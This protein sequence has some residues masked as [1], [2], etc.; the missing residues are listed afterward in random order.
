MAP[1]RWVH[2]RRRSRGCGS[3][4]R[5]RRW[6]LR[7]E[8]GQVSAIA[9]ILALLL[10]VTFIANYLTT[11]LPNQMAINDLQRDL[12][13][14]NQVGRL[15]TLLQ[16]VTSPPSIGVQVS[17]P[18]TLGSSG[19]PPFAG[20]D[21]GSL[22]ALANGSAATVAY[23]LVG[24]TDLVTPSVTA[25]GSS[26]PAGTCTITTTAVTCASGGGR[27]WGNFTA[28]N[29][30]FTATLTAGETFA[31]L[32]YSTSGSTIT[33]SA[34]STAATHVEV[35]GSSDTISVSN[36]GATV[37]NVTV[38]GS[39]DT[40][41]LANSGGGGKERALIVGSND[42][43]SATTGGSSLFAISFFGSS[44]TF[45]PP[46]ATSSGANVYAVYFN[47][48]STSSPSL[49]CPQGNVPTNDQV[50]INPS[51]WGN[52]NT[53]KIFFNDTSGTPG[54]TT[55][56]T[57]WTNTTQNP[58]AFAC[59]FVAQ[60]SIPV[61]SVVSPG[62]GFDVHLANTYAPI[63]DVALDEGA[64]VFSQAG[65]S[66]VMEDGPQISLTES[67]T[68][69]TSLAI[70]FPV[71]SGVGAFPSQSGYGT[72]DVVAR[73]LAVT[74]ISLSSGGAFSLSPTSNVVLTV[75]TAFATAWVTWIE[76]QGWGITPTCTPSTGAACAGPY[77][78][79]G[80]TTAVGTVSLTIP[81]SHLTSLTVTTA[82]FAV[83][84]D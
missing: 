35:F 1:N 57:G 11:S 56:A 14:T 50:L 7:S 23:T 68:N 77:D 62:A 34:G 38:V 42:A 13:V 47:G 72:A 76:G 18:I 15:T 79:H 17:Q 46:A 44:D 71:F 19:D 9:T 43:V 4:R 55:P 74:T 45:T 8:S 37:A 67:G 5:P 32:N 53:M 70:W 64:V 12:I 83:G 75:T 84:L 36:T 60:V 40:I 80:P 20:S 33:V 6:R 25:G 10:V 51:A 16:A 73:L 69:V 22:S 52:G 63:A 61:N 48:F 28:N 3:G 21:G 58:T 2:A 30:T 65:G 82:T 59:P 29:Q 26:H 31:S 39:K 78:P 24:P 41:T 27:I 49:S 66:P 54:S 81:A